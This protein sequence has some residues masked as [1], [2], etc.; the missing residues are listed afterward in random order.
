ML[1]LKSPLELGGSASEKFKDDSFFLQRH[2]LFE[3]LNASIKYIPLKPQQLIFP[4]EHFHST[5]DF[6]PSIPFL[7]TVEIRRKII[8]HF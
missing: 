7:W 2:L 1:R 6:I 5:L 3:W 8:N 4:L